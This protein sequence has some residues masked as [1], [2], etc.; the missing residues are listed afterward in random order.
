ME[1]PKQYITSEER[2]IVTDADD[3]IEKFEKMPSAISILSF[4]TGQ[5]IIESEL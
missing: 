2:L 1:R 5:F 3:C 4:A